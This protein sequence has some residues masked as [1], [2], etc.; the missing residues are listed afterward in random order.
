MI[1]PNTFYRYIREY[2]A[3]MQSLI[4]VPFM[5]GGGSVSDLVAFGHV[6]KDYDIYFRNYEDMAAFELRITE[7]GY[8]LISE[9]DLG[10]QYELSNTRFDIITWHVK[11]PEDFIKTFDFTVNAIMLDGNILY[12]AETTIED[13][14][15]KRLRP[16]RTLNEQ[17]GYRIKRY[18]EK[19]YRV[20]IDSTLL[21]ISL[22][23]RVQNEVKP[24]RIIGV[25]LSRY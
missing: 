24:A 16:V 20:D 22:N 15:Y 5:I 23:R 11:T 14:M 21:D 17:Y 1:I 4:G 7:L 25:D 8:K 12:H 3:P 19:G 9:T 2:F 13:C 10:R 18:I 6:L